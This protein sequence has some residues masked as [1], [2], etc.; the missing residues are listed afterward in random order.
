MRGFFIILLL[1]FAYLM[2]RLPVSMIGDIDALH[3]AQALTAL[4]FVVLAGHLI[5]KLLGRLK[6]PQVT[7]YMLTGLIAG[8][9]IFG[10]ISENMM[11][12]LH[13]IDKIALVL[14]ALSAGGKLQLSELKPRI[15][16]IFSVLCAQTL[17]IL[18][19]TVV[20]FL[21]IAGWLLES[22]KFSILQ[23]VAVAL[24]LGVMTSANSPSVAVAVVTELRAK[25]RL[26]DLVMSVTVVKD[27]VVI[28]LFTF[29]MAFASKVFGGNLSDVRETHQPLILMIGMSLLFG[30]IGGKLL[31][32]YLK[33]L[34]KH[35]EVFLILLT[36]LVINLVDFIALELLLTALTMGFVVE[37]FSNRGEMLI[38]GLERISPPIYVIFFAMAGASI[39]L[40]M[41]G[42]I[43]MIALI[44]TGFRSFS[45]WFGTW[46]GLKIS[47]GSKEERKLAWLGYLPQAGVA[48]GMASIVATSFPGWGEQIRT[49]ILA[50]VAINQVAGPVGFRF[51]LVRSGEGKG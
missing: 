9:Y 5:G 31:H 30:I 29:A 40:S 44:W 32:Y 22:D 6:L 37:N 21:S 16:T 51:A 25:G 8:P 46:L 12:R 34:K 10:I 48:L 27:V 28:V 39:D 15:K 33:Y 18:V 23:I 35:F 49:L 7:G 50:V 45:L 14:I 41:M 38:K 19:L 20:V 24:T 11:E 43:G 36:I 2:S 42:K 47:Q 26:T 3:D 1:T 13:I 4:G 17:T